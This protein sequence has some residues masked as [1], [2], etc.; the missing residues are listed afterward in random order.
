MTL[1]FQ[2]ADLR[3]ACASL[4]PVLSGKSSLPVLGAVQFSLDC[5]GVVV[6]ASNLDVWMSVA[7]TDFQGDEWTSREM[8]SE[9]VPPQ[10]FRLPGRLLHEALARI[11]ADDLKLTVEGSTAVLRA[12]SAKLSLPLITEPFPALP[13]A[14]WSKPI[15]ID[16]LQ[17]KLKLALPYAS[18]DPT[19]ATLCGIYLGDHRI[20]AANGKQ[21]IRMEE[22]GLKKANAIVPSELCHLIAKTEGAV[23]LRL[24]DSLLEAAGE[25]WTVTG[26]LIESETKLWVNTAPLYGF[27]PTMTVSGSAKAMAD[28]CSLAAFSLPSLIDAVKVR[29]T[30]DTLTFWTDGGEV[31]CHALCSG[32]IQPWAVN[33]RYFAT[34]LSSFPDDHVK[35]DFSDC[36]AI[37]IQQGPVK[38]LTQLMRAN[39]EQ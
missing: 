19:R 5:L 34:L 9:I 28:A 29:C 27:T 30:E 24:T 4:Q 15:L 10:S 37:R 20:E 2:T 12:G 35:I 36:G 23:T 8:S 14:E 25:G 38:A 22:P 13:D 18:K 31:E 32:N 7:I 39:L 21:S 33:A 16:D 17:A 6:R 1:H 26:K 11:T 3:A